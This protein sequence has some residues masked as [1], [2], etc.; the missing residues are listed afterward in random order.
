MI[1]L[2]T[3]VLSL[4]LVGNGGYVSRLN[5]L[6]PDEVCVTVVALEEAMRGRLDGIRKA[7]QSDRAGA[8][9]AAYERFQQGFTDLRAYRVLPYTAAAHELFLA[10]RAGKIRV[11][12]QDL[13]VA[14]ICVAHDADLVSRNRRDFNRVPALK[15]TVWN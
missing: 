15:L 7:Q 4:I 3:D 9:A 11:G 1:A 14:A 2:D 8:L 6:P 5:E 12:T 13:R 10:W